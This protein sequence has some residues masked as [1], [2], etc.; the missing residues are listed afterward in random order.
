M[1]DLTIDKKGNIFVKGKRLKG[2]RLFD[3]VLSLRVQ[4]GGVGVSIAEQFVQ[5]DIRVFLVCL[6][7]ELTR[8]TNSE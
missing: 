6:I 1:N 7:T 4:S 5:I 3:N 2:M 8:L